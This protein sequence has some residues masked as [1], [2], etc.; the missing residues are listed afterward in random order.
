MKK[1]KIGFFANRAQRGAVALG[2]RLSRVAAGLGLETVP[3]AEADIVVALNEVVVM[4]EMTGHAALLEVAVGG[5][6]DRK[7]TRLN[8]S[9]D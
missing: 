2:K 7:S 9:H 4:R 8:S 6:R 3:D 5:K 1:T